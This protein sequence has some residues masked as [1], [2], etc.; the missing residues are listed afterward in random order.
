MEHDNMNLGSTQIPNFEITPEHY[1]EPKMHE[2]SRFFHLFIIEP[3]FVEKGE[4]V[5]I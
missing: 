1:L 2:I 5:L 3:F 4:K